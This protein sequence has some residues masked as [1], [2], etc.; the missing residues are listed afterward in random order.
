MLKK[1]MQ[2]MYESSA[3]LNKQ[4]I[5]SLILS[6]K[7]KPDIKMLDL[8][9]D[10]GEWTLTLAER[11]GANCIYGIEIVDE[12]IQKAKKRGIKVTK[13]DLNAKFPFRKNY[14]DVIHANQVIE[15]VAS[16]D[17]FVQEMYRILKPGGCVIVSTENQ[18]SWHNILATIL[19]WQMFSLT[20]VSAKISGIGNPL[21]L[22]HG[23]NNMPSSWTHKTIM[24]LKGLKE[25]F[26]LYNFSNITAKGAGYY[27]LPCSFGNID[28]SHSHF[29]TIC[30]FK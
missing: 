24:S 23:V 7:N 26:A 2:K 15:H 22:H 8:G 1:I 5:I 17:R 20:N 6:Q 3:D 21:A 25:L 4:N 12:Q 29:I 11:I 9:C 13:S 18:C 10:D 28:K 16:L 14:F 30:G 19:G 27:P